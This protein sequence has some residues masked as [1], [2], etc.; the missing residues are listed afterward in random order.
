MLCDADTADWDVETALT[1]SPIDPHL[2]SMYGTRALAAFVRDA[3]DEAV[4]YAER[5]MRSPN[6]HLYVYMIAAAV[7]SRRGDVEKAQLCV[8]HI[9]R[10]NVPFGKQ[11]FLAHFNLR[12][13]AKLDMLK[14]SLAG[15]GI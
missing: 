4:L 5:A 7:H 2:Q 1:L 12:D 14:Q 10:K 9:R 8:E 3:M 13:A 6:A 11:D 15:L